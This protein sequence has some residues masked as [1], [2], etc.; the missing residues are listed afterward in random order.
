MALDATVQF[1]G[2]TYSVPFRFAEQTVEVRGCAATVQ[3]WADGE[4]V[5]SHPRGTRS[6][7]VL[8]PTHYDGP[9]TDR[10]EAPVPLGR[11]GRKLQELWAMA[12]ERR[13]IEQYA[14]LAGVAR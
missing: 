13:S 1:E 4:V 14:A 2:R 8:D 11:M 7:I 10:V 9:S 5:A 3:V 12:P 6:R